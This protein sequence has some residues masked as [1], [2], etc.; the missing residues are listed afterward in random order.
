M[1]PLTLRSR[2]KLSKKD[3]LSYLSAVQC[4]LTKSPTTP[5]NEAPGVGSRFDD[6][7]ATHIQQT[8]SIHYVGHFLPWHR[9]YTAIYE[10]ALRDECGYIGA[11]PYALP[12]T[13]PTIFSLTIHKILGLGTGHP[14]LGNF[15]TSPLWDAKYGFGGGCITTGPLAN[16]TVR[17]G[18]GD[19]VG[20]NP[21]CLKRDWSPYF[22]GRYLGLNVTQHTIEQSDFGW[23][24]TAVQGGPS[25]D[26]SGLHGGGHYGVGGTLGE[27]GDLYNSPADP[28]FYLHHANLDRVWW[29][30]QKK[31]LTTRLTDI[32]GPIYIM[33]YTNEKG[34][35][36]MLDFPLSVGVNAQNV[37]IGDVMDVRGGV[38][39]YDYDEIYEF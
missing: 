27:M 35:N 24:D 18:P 1:P 29:S 7:I 38:L 16:M 8:Y 4:I 21:R 20:G 32:S 2:R 33:D 30:W 6:F 3:Q 11:Q 15:T 17:M 26:L 5:L 34:G 22:A 23:F 31:N 37:T 39:C 19:D 25:F 36:V 13:S 14:P 28:V 10:K 9:Y 12:S